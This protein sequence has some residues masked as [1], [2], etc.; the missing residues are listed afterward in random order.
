MCKK[1]LYQSLV[2]LFVLSAIPSYLLTEEI[3]PVTLLKPQVTTGKPLMQVFNKRR[4][5]REF[6]KKKLPIQV[7]SNLLWAAN[8]VNR[9]DSGKRVAPSAIN[10]QEI[11]IYVALEEA[12]YRYDAKNHI[13]APVISKDIRGD[14]GKQAFVKHAPVNLIYV[15]DMSRM[16]QIKIE[17]REFYAATD[18]GFISQNV[19]LFCASEGLATVVRGLID[20]TALAEKMELKEFQKIILSQTIGYPK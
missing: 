4:S 17:D 18:T 13:L 7:L 11:D 2:I 19:Y 8:G 16:K 15:A 12:L 1:I 14:T 3:E 6:S 5:T 9:P 10:M 20:K